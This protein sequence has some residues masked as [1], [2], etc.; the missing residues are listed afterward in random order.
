MLDG[1]RPRC[2]SRALSSWFLVYALQQECSTRLYL[3]EAQPR[4]HTLSCHCCGNCMHSGSF[5]PVPGGNLELGLGEAFCPK[6]WSRLWPSDGGDWRRYALGLHATCHT[7]PDTVVL[8]LAFLSNALL[9]ATRLTFFDIPLWSFRPVPL[10]AMRVRIPSG[11]CTCACTYRRCDSAEASCTR[12]GLH[13]HTT[14][15]TRLLC[16]RPQDLVVW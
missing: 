11:M 14:T 7:S 1:S 2:Q 3:P 4:L 5:T 16:M 12:F 8:D 9:A 6:N 15:T 13:S 10:A